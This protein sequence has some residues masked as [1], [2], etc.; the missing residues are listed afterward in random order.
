M[1]DLDVVIAVPA[2]DRAKTAKELLDAFL[3]EGRRVFVLPNVLPADLLDDMLA[4][5]KVRYLGMPRL[6]IEVAEP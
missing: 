4:G 1:L 5:K 2:L 3:A 6:L